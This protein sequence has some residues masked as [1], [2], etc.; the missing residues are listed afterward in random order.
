MVRFVKKNQ[1]IDLQFEMLA[2][3]AG[4]LSDQQID[5]ILS[6]L[7]AILISHWERSHVPAAKDQAENHSSS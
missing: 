7:A 3:D 6:D 2:K 5:E 1:K 4:T